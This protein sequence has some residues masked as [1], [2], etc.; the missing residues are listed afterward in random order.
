LIQAKVGP[1]CVGQVCIGQAFPIT[2]EWSEQTVTLHADA[3]EWKCMG[4]RHDRTNSYGWGNVADVL[5]DVNEN[6]LFVLHPLDVVP[7]MPLNGDPHLLKAG[8]D[9]AVDKTRLPEG[10]V[11]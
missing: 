9:Y 11:M 5:R 7:A 8:E 4:S 3:E 6:I 2:P 10:H 1:V